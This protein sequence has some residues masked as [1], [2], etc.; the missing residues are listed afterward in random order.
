MKILMIDDKR[1]IKGAEIARNYREGLDYL[2]QGGKW[3]ILYLDHDLGE[4]LLEPRLGH[5]LRGAHALL[6]LA[7]REEP[8]HDRRLAKGPVDLVRL[9]PDRPPRFR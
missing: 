6:K 8:T 2:E 4:R 7:L 1:T 3:D 9:H 5:Q